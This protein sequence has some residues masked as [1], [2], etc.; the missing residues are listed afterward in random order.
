MT[1]IVVTVGPLATA[2]DDGYATNQTPG[3]AGNLT[4]NGALVSGGVGIADLAR[5]VLLTSAGDESGKTVTIYGTNWA[6]DAIY[7]TLTGP[8]TTATSVLSYKTVTRIAVSAA[9]G[10]NVK[11][12]TSPVADSPWARLDSWAGPNVA[13]QCTVSGT[14]N[15]DVESTM[16]DPNS[17][18]NPILPGAM[19]WV[20]SNDSNVVAA[21]ATKQS[22]FLFP[23]TWA[24]VTLNSGTG[25]VV[26]TF[27]QSG[28]V[29]R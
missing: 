17:A 11:A 21:T 2:D 26:S 25:Y 19:T 9:F 16:D 24:R 18:T 6:G 15:Y 7:E 23:P 14:V 12:G 20:N 10:G 5:R 3:A 4:L 13:I 28:V 27:S 1:P 8:N 22:N 29:N